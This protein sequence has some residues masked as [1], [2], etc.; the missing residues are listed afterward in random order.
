MSI[1]KEIKRARQ[2]KEWTQSKLSNEL[3]SIG[4]KSSQGQIASYENG[5]VHP[6]SDK[7]E[8][9]AKALGGEWKLVRE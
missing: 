5:V 3:E 7:L 4:E 8:N 6:S 1:K 9:I 2:Y